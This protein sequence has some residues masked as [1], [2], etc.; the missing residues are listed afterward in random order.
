MNQTLKDLWKKNFPLWTDVLLD[1][2]ADQI[3][4]ES[5]YFDAQFGAPQKQFYADAIAKVNRSVSFPN[6][7]GQRDVFQDISLFNPTNPKYTINQYWES[8]WI[9]PYAAPN[10]DLYFGGPM[11]DPGNIGRANMDDLRSG[12]AQAPFRKFASNYH[13]NSVWDSRLFDTFS[14]D[15]GVQYDRIGP[16]QN[17]SFLF[18]M[19]YSSAPAAPVNVTFFFNLLNPP[20]KYAQSDS[21]IALHENGKDMTGIDYAKLYEFNTYLK[22]YQNYGAQIQGAADVAKKTAAADILNYKSDLDSKLLAQKNNLQNLTLQLTSQTAAEAA[23]AKRDMQQL[24]LQ[25]ATIKLQI[26][27]LVK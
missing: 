6:W 8:G 17:L 1:K 15:W 10:V 26:M 12:S 2:F 27:G 19:S 21:L 4:I 11:I 13:V 5:N 24:S 16:N 9:F 3:E 25:V 20:K 18:I 22:A 14:I 7:T 23:S